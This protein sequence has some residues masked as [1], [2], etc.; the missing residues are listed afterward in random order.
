MWCEAEDLTI[1]VPPP[2]HPADSKACNFPAIDALI[3]PISLLQ[4]TIMQKYAI[5]TA[6][7]TKAQKQLRG[8]PQRLY[9]VVPA[10]L[11]DGYSVVA[12]TGSIQ[13]WVLKMAWE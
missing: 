13:Q 7:L 2:L 11:Y 5:N 12:G 9:F 10:S 8:S 1:L 6:G 4:V 3:Q